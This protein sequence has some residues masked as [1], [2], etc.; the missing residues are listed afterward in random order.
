MVATLRCTW[1]IRYAK[2][3]ARQRFVVA[4][5]FEWHNLFDQSF[6]AFTHALFI[7]EFKAIGSTAVRKAL[8][9]GESMSHSTW[10]LCNIIRVNYE[11]PSILNS[12]II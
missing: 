11:L 4:H 3:A 2:I 12:S 7:I 9:C 1:P 5:V 10:I 6:I 8:I